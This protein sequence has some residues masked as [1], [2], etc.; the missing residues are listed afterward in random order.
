MVIPV[1]LDILQRHVSFETVEITK[2]LAGS[3]YSLNI[4][5]I[6]YIIYLEILILICGQLSSSHL[7]VN[8]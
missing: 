5:Y 3:I 2:E 8:M 6:L 7:L 1:Y 4:L